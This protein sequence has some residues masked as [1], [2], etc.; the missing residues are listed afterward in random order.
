MEQSILSLTIMKQPHPK[1]STMN[2]LVLT[3]MQMPKQN[4]VAMVWPHSDLGVAKVQTKKSHAAEVMGSI[5]NY[6]ARH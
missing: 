4:P 6:V 1:S 2:S 5:P 3:N